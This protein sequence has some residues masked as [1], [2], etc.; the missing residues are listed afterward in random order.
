MQFYFWLLKEEDLILRS[1]L[2]LA[3]TAKKYG[4]EAP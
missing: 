2:T 4:A 3:V 1:F